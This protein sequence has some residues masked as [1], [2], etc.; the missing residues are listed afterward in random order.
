MIGQR[1]QRGSLIAVALVV[2]TGVANVVAEDLICDNTPD[3]AFVGN[4]GDVEVP[5]GAICF[6]DGAEVED[7]KV[8]GGLRA[9]RTVIRGD[10][11]GEPGHESILMG[12]FAGV[13]NTV[14]GDVQIKGG[15]GPGF[16]GVV[17][18]MIHG[19]LRAEENSNGLLFGNNLIGGDL[20]VFA[21]TGVLP[22]DGSSANIGG[23]TIRGDL[24]CKENNPLPL[25]SPLFGVNAVGGDKEDQCSSEHGF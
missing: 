23:N 5:P 19:D 7:V 8:F 17:G 24:Q 25:V 6:L 12:F 14:H 16:S 3:T 13:G 4:A 1:N 20:Q 15:V 10:V 22:E 21:N 11:Q 9:R 18:A 2:F